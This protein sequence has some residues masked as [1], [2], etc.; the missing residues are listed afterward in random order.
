MSS[1]DICQMA[2]AGYWHLHPEHAPRRQVLSDGRVHTRKIR[3]SYRPDRTKE[4]P[5][6]QFVRLK[7]AYLKGI[8]DHLD[9][10]QDCASCM[11]EIA[12]ELASRMAAAQAR[13]DFND[14]G[15]G[16]YVMVRWLWERDPA[17][18]SMSWARVQF[19]LSN[20]SPERMA[21]LRK[22]TL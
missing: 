9:T 14:V 2:V 16:G 11:G 6:R 22:A 21:Q 10:C 15:E 1:I 3:S 8:R 7:G 20:A 12:A 13:R 17:G 4:G 5:I 19:L 18:V